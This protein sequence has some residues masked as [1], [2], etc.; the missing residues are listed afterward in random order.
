MRHV[1]AEVPLL[2][3]ACARTWMYAACQRGERRSRNAVGWGSCFSPQ[4]KYWIEQHSLA[5]R[6][7]T[8]SK[9]YDDGDHK[10]DGEENWLNR[11]IG[12]ENRTPHLAGEQNSP[13]IACGAAKQG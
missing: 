12:V 10:N 9:G 3:R 11:D 13:S 8:S 7:C 6:C 1:R 5:N 2:A 4:C